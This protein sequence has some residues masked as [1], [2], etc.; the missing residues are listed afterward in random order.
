MEALLADQ[1]LAMDWGELAR[2]EVD[3]DLQAK[4]AELE[5]MQGSSGLTKVF[6]GVSVFHKDPVVG[7]DSGAIKT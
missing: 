6:G 3:K 1:N 7:V 4:K 2:E 5:K